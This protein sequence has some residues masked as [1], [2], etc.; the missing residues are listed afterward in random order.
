MKK[1]ELQVQYMGGFSL[2]WDGKPLYLELDAGSKPLQLLRMLLFYRAKG[3]TRAFAIEN[4]FGNEDSVN[5]VN[6]LRNTRFR[7]KKLLIEAGLP[8]CEYILVRGGRLYWDEAVP[9][10]LDVELFDKA[11]QKALKETKAD[12]RCAA[13]LK[14]CELYQGALLPGDAVLPWVVVENQRLTQMYEELVQ[15]ACAGMEAEQNWLAA[16][17]LYTK[18]SELQPYNEQWAIG[19]MRCLQS[20]NRHKEALQ[21]YEETVTCLMDS[22]GIA[23]S[24]ALRRCLD[25]AGEG[26]GFASPLEIVECIAEGF[27]G[28]ARYCHFAEF[29][30]CCG[31]VTKLEARSGRTTSLLWCTVQPP[32]NEAEGATLR[33]DRV[34][35]CMIQ[36]LNQTLRGSD[37]FTRY[38][39]DQ[40][41]ILLPGSGDEGCARVFERVNTRFKAQ[42]AA[43]GYTLTLRLVPLTQPG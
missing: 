16:Q 9:V 18:A 28:G 14:A 8:E 35:E 23:P 37:L 31:L 36:T 10:S 3:I 19:S 29:V 39:D 20:M 21:L 1:K 24:E 11:A 13:A 7:L 40:Y 38:G 12:K 42:K 33:K 15:E 41:L 22:F 30:H 32:Q 34:A 17:E 26:T 27:R 43:Y 25:D 5:P 6:N 2:K 4:L